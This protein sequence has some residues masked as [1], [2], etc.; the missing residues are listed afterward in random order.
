MQL[1]LHGAGAVG[2]AIGLR[3]VAAE[4]RPRTL[5][6]PWARDHPRTRVLGGIEAVQR[7]EDGAICQGSGS[8]AIGLGV[9]ARKFDSEKESSVLECRRP[10][11]YG[12]R[13]A[14]HSFR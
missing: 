13:V 12:L 4:G 7:V 1:L 14:V 9:D 3:V 5:I 2:H 11:I 10:P 6:L 8:A